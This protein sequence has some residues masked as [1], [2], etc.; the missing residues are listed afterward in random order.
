MQLLN[1]WYQWRPSG[2]PMTHS[3]QF[4]SGDSAQGL[5]TSWEDEG[6]RA[7]ADLAQ[8]LLPEETELEQVSDMVLSHLLLR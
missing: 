1:S 2:D 7:P 3:A 8:Y 4:V 5:G 6:Q